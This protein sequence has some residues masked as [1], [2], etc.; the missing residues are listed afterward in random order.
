VNAGVG[1]IG[2]LEKGVTDP[3]VPV[4]EL[5]LRDMGVSETNFHFC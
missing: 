4:L 2:S 5:G 1:E 3:L